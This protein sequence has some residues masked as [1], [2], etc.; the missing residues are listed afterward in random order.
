MKKTAVNFMVNIYH[1][2]RSFFNTIKY[3]IKLICSRNLKNHINE[4]NNANVLTILANGPSLKEDIDNI[5]FTEGDF[6]VLNNFYNSPYFEKIKP[7]YYVLADP[8]YFTGSCNIE[9]LLRAIKNDIILFVPFAAL[10][11]SNSLKE[12]INPH[13]NIV[14][15]Q[16]LTYDGFE[17]LRNWLYRQGLAMPRA[18]NVLVPSIF[19]A[20]NMGYKEIRI[21]G[22][23]HSWTENIRVDDKNRVCLTDSHF[24]DTEEA[25]MNPW[26][27]CNGEQYLM[28]EILRDL[29]WMFDSYHQIRKY[30]DKRKCLVLNYTKKSFIDAFERM[31][32]K[33]A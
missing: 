14:P 25:K 9:P 13:I 4:V 17:F 18:Q 19:N 31:G 8:S 32:E 28:H 30:A 23:D 29:A 16:S 7:K 1:F 2:L 26:L 12:V 21:Y 11:I 22:A 10:K 5:D 24:Y 27:K 20:I 33:L 15:F 3:F 6:L